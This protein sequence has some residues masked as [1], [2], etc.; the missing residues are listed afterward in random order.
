MWIR[1]PG[2]GIF[3]TLDPG[4]KSSDP[5]YKQPGSATWPIQNLILV[6]T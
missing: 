4:M 5:G 3:L 2:T 1:I 6:V